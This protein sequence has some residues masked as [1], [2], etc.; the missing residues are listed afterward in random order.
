[1][2]KFMKG[3]A[4]MPFLDHLEELRWRILYSLIAFCVG[5]FVAFVL[6]Q[7]VDVIR[8]LERPVLPYLHGRKLVFTHPGDP[9]GIVLNAAFAL[10]V[11]LALPVIGY[12]AW[13]FFAPALYAH[14]KKLVVP[15]LLGAVGLFLAGVALSF[16][17]VLPFTLGFLLN[18]QTEAL[19]PMITA[20]EY[21]GFAISMSLAFGAVFEL[22][23]LILA[24]TALGIVT[25]A[26][27]SK[28]RRHAIVLCVV[29]AAFITPGADPTSLFALSVPL[30]LLFELSVVLSKAIYARRQRRALA[31]N[32][33][34]TLDQP[35][36][37]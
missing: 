10:G 8:F 2:A 17:V 13:A 9:F 26:F 21:F 35:G 22:P 7:K 31:D 33:I 24:L 28:Y 36:A 23:I 11:I 37:A 5:L 18:F 14:E 34:G 1:M 20:S 4:E 30:Y 16:Y 6:L 32:T 29:G 19:E 25:P 15:V 3:S 27:L 12:Q